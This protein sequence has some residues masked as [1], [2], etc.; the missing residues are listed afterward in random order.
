MADLITSL[1]TQTGID[2][3]TVRKGLGALLSSLQGHL[4]PEAFGRVQ[5]AVPDAPELIAAFESGKGATGPGLFGKAA[6]LAGNL[7]GGRAGGGANLL[8]MLSQAGLDTD[9]VQAFLPKALEQLRGVL[10]PD[11]FDQIQAVTPAPDQIA[12]GARL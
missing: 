7:L 2:P 11:L 4:G 5:A 6:Q 12:G 9:Q 8:A 1:A 3:G 10:P